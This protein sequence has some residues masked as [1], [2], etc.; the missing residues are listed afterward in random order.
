MARNEEKAQSMLY[1][2]REAQMA[3]M[4]IVKHQRRPY[5]SSECDNVSDGEKWRHQIVRE[6]AQKVAKIQDSGLTEHQ[7]R[8]LNDEI[9][10]L[11]REKRHWEY[12]IKELGGSDYTRLGGK[13]Y[14]SEG[15]EVPGVRGYKYF[16]RAKELPGV[17]E[18][19]AQEPAETE[20]KTQYELQKIVDGDYFGYRDEE[21]GMLLDYES[22]Y[23]ARE[24]EKINSREMANRANGN[25]KRNQSGDIFIA[26]MPVPDQKEI[27]EWFVI[28][29]KKEL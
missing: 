24:C 15:K 12:R 17:K 3:E 6:V 5:R 10:R 18:L 14:D 2:F 29:R 7:V 19:F 16:G 13:Q 21:D 25:S 1:R 8:D 11:L 20:A 26:Y 22:K 28:R 23:T 9:N 4:G 27:E